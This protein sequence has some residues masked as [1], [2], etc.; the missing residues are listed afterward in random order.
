MSK[1]CMKCGNILSDEALFCARC[2]KPLSQDL[3]HQQNNNQWNNPNGQGM[4]NQWN[5]QSGRQQAIRVDTHKIKNNLMQQ[6]RKLSS[7]GNKKFVLIGIGIIALLIV[8]IALF[9]I[10]RKPSNHRLKQQF[11]MNLLTYEYENEVRT[12]KLKSLKVERRMSGK[13]YDTAYCKV[14]LEDEIMT[15]ILYVE[16]NSQKY[17]QG[18]WNVTYC[19]IYQ[20]DEIIPKITPDD[21]VNKTEI[22]P[23][24]AKNVQVK[25]NDDGS[26]TYTMDVNYEGL[27]GN[28][29]TGNLGVTYKMSNLSEERE[30]TL[31]EV[32]FPMEYGWSTTNRDDSNLQY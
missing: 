32:E 14:E 26:Y 31:T 9:I 13:D 23:N 8:L 6:S 16:M 24:N 28:T 18:G 19:Y 1:I 12:S 22:Q 2:G 29:I 4:N 27:Y 3:N 7:G 17:T 20:T 5:N 15:R 10:G 21:Y 30:D 25:K 11:P